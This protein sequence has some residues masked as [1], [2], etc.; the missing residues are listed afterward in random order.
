MLVT[1]F[2]LY[3]PHRVV[4]YL[5][6]SQE[7]QNPR[8]PDQQ[9]AVIR[10][11]IKRLGLPWIIVAVYRDDFISARFTRKR[12]S[13]Q[14]MLK[15]LKTG[16]VQ[17]TL[18]LVDTFERL[19]RADN[20]DSIRESL[21]KIGV[22]VLTANSNFNDPT[23]S[24]GR[25]LSAFE[26]LRASEDG[27]VKAHNVLRGKQDAVRLKQWPGGAAPFGFYL[28]AVFKTENGLQ[29]I[30]YRIPKPN[31]ATKWI[32][33]E[34]FRLADEL[35]YG[36]SRIAK[37]LNNDSRIPEE[38]KPFHPATIGEILDNE[39]HI[40]DYIWGKN[41]TGI[42]DEVRV[43]QPL[44]KE[45]WL[46]ITEFCEPII[47][48]ERWD[49]VQA[50]R[51]ARRE[52]CPK[53]P[54][55]QPAIAGL[56]TPGIALKYPLT[57]L[58]FC[59]HC[60]RR[61]NPQ[62]SSEYQSVSGDV[63][64]Y[65]HYGCTGL[66]GGL[67]DNRKRIPEDW[68]R[69]I[70]VSLM[71]SRLQLDDC[72]P[73]STRLLEFVE[74]VRRELELH[75]A[76]QPD[77]T[78]A[79]QAE[80]HDLEARCGGWTQSLGNRDLSAIVRHTIEGELERAM[81]RIQQIEAEQMARL[82]GTQQRQQVLDPQEISER[83]QR[84]ATMLNEGNASAMNLMLSHHIDSIWCDDSGHVV[85]RTCKLGALA[86]DLTLFIT[87]S[88]RLQGSASDAVPAK[89]CAKPRRRARLDIKGAIEDDEAEI[90][91]N[92]FAVDTDRFAGL[93]PEW[94]AE[95]HFD[96]PETLSWAQ[97]NAQAVAEFRLSTH[98]SMEVT[99]K[100]FNKTTPTIR[101]ALNYAKE[102]YGIDAF[103]K[104]ISRPTLPNWSRANAQAVV[105][106]MSQPDVTMK[107]AV[108]HFERTEPTIRKALEFA[109]SAAAQADTPKRD[110]GEVDSRYDAA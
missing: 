91:A 84:L 19:T 74:I 51:Q 68:L 70:V 40:G 39:M 47:A 45:E 58:V 3:I 106:F 5:R 95:D 94:F 109:K 97:A 25:A 42:V 26:A 9:E 27:K 1:K 41:C 61:M 21:R 72:G 43:V 55:T 73:T 89:F 16:V 81:T 31:P 90:E 99:A 44:P 100:H 20:G 7:G 6:M 62:S 50:L 60:H 8:S 29:V 110:D 63:R 82:A 36:T 104:S 98:S 22:L 14:R 24:S 78:A 2:D 79:L 30:A 86:G 48:R 32:V 23:S 52:K 85:I 101:A 107:M 33:E 10:E 53:K 54:K 71:R 87:D 13:F 35:G 18:V 65:V 56:A 69:G 28:E 80:Q 15:D 66:A 46:H 93:G 37:A 57:G 102:K 108:A 103:G 67:C 59:A 64:R 96:V 92:E 11:L 105:E 83:L 88:S 34:I 75:Q 12:P 77:P 38:L 76:L 4:I 49:R 17:A